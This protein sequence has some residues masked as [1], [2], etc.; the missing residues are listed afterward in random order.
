MVSTA[1]YSV[2]PNDPNRVGILERGPLAAVLVAAVLGLVL[3]FP[4]VDLLYR[5]KN[6]SEADTELTI[7]YLRNVLRAEQQDLALHLLLAEKL[8]A[9]NAFGD[10]QR[11]LVAAKPYAMDGEALRAWK[12]ADLNVAWQAYF[13]QV[14]QNKT[15]ASAATSAELLAARQAVRDRVSAQL[16]AEPRVNPLFQLFTQAQSLDDQASAKLAL[17]RLAEHP[18]LGFADTAR[19]ARELLAYGDFAHAAQLYFLAKTRT[20]DG[21]A[22]R[23]MVDLGVRTLLAANQP[24]AAYRAAV[25]EYDRAPFGDAL[26]WELAN[27][28]LAAALP[29]Q[30]AIHVR[31]VVQANWG[32]AQLAA[33]TP[34]QLRKVQDVAFASGDLA[35]ASAVLQARVRQQ[36]D[37]LGL[38]ERIAQVAEWAGRPFDALDAWLTLAKTTA[39]TQALEQ[40]LR[41]SPMLNDDEALIWAWRKRGS[42]SALSAKEEDLLLAIL[43]RVGRPQDAVAWIDAQLTRNTRQQEASTLLAKRARLFVRMAKTDDAIAAFQRLAAALDSSQG[44]LMRDDALAWADL[45]LRRGQ[46]AQALVALARYRAPAKPD[47]QE[48]LYWDIRA[49]VA[50]ELGGMDDAMQSWRALKA[51]RVV[52]LAQM[53]RKPMAA[54]EL[55]LNQY[56]AERYLRIAADRLPTTEALAL[57]AALYA[58]TP[59]DGLLYIWTDLLF[60][61]PSAERVAQLNAALVGEERKRLYQSPVFLRR[62]AGLNAAT[63]QKRLALSQYQ[64]A[65][66]RGAEPA[67][68]LD[69]WWLLVDVADTQLLKKELAAQRA[70]LAAKPEFWEVLGASHVLL[71]QP[72]LALSFYVRIAGDAS[73]SK[74]NDYLWLANFA[75]VLEQAGEASMALRVRRQVHLLLNATVAQIRGKAGVLT[76]VDAQALLVKARTG[77]FRSAAEHDWAMQRLGQIALGTE[78][79][80]ALRQ[81]ADSLLLN[82]ALAGDRIEW[83]RRWL[84]QR[85]AQRESGQNY[86]RLA[87]A[88]AEGDQASLDA[89]MESSAQQ[90]QAIDRHNALRQLGRGREALVQAV[91]LSQAGESPK[92]EE[93]QQSIDELTRQQTK[94]VRVTTVSQNNAAFA[95]RGMRTQLDAPFSPSLRMSLDMAKPR[96]PSFDRLSVAVRV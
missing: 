63:G 30:A 54:D 46:F 36:P 20:T 16:K 40:V 49:D 4:K 47:P 85:Q 65:L 12:Q 58:S 3:V 87:L 25:R 77:G 39:S 21:D 11:V 53:H 74:A 60:A 93:L 83:A 80:A 75:D 28:A 33:L 48:Q 78:Q 31:D 66:A 15:S 23:R 79:T 67:T 6:H 22:R 55:A 71:S 82:K 76:A 38:R 10:A 34:E 14:E 9:K 64:E 24:E 13:W 62:I 8:A 90:F 88:L 68:R 7:S 59:A 41:L 37:D 29:A 56:Q 19:V 50:Y 72:R 18:Q 89:L 57:A 92:S 91:Q 44:A 51:I 69:F 94:R 45:H 95:V 42:Q 27:L 26:H 32:V 52:Q 61:S 5:L 1:Q 86:A 43:E 35:W 2:A 96:R 84:W 81:Q 73:Q 17:Q 70:E